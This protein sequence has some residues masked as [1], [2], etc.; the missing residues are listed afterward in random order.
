MGDWLWGVGWFAVGI[1]LTPLVLAGFGWLLDHIHPPRWL[2][3][4]WKW[5]SRRAFGSGFDE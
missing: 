5:G 1:M 3:R 4:Y 2:A